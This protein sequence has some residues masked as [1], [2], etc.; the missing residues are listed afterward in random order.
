[1]KFLSK[2]KY[3]I[4]T[5]LFI[6][7]SFICGLSFA[8]TE[9]AYFDRFLTQ[10]NIPNEHNYYNGF[11]SPYLKIIKGEN[12]IVSSGRKYDDILAYFTYDEFT[13]GCRQLVDNDVTINLAEPIDIKILT[14]STFK[15]L[16]DIDSKTNYYPVD[17]NMYQSYYSSSQLNGIYR[18]ELP[19]FSSVPV[20]HQARFGADTF[21]YISDTL[22][23]KLITHYGIDEAEDPYAELIGNENFAFLHLNVD[24]VAN[25]MTASINS[26]ISSRFRFAP[27]VQTI[28]GDF[29]LAFIPGNN[30][31]ITSLSL[32]VD[33]KVNQYGNKQTLDTISR[34][35][36][37]VNNSTF[38]FFTYDYANEQYVHN[39]LLDKKFIDLYSTSYFPDVVAY[40]LVALFSVLI[41]LVSFLKGEYGN[42]ISKLLFFSNYLVFFA[43]GIIAYF[44]DLFPMYSI[45]PIVGMILISIFY[46]KGVFKVHEVK[47]PDSECFEISI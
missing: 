5:I 11:I 26:I 28:Y 43:Y 40:V 32:D 47:K 19:E 4:A 13:N 15:I 9:D 16:D 31:V 20:E 29:A 38:N 34:L 27:Q 30:T 8:Y 37:G 3:V 45:F 1:M 23:D 14:Q 39:V 18:Q 35:D 7:S 2:Y 12:K 44:V 6:F 22:A 21:I 36:Y 33:F 41:L 17:K 24:G 10:I 42:N 25:I 46:L